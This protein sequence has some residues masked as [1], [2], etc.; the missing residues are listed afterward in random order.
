MTDIQARL[1]TVVGDPNL[2]AGDTI[3][4]PPAL[5]WLVETPL[6]ILR[7]EQIAACPVEGLVVGG[8]D[9]AEGL[10]AR[11]TPSRAPLLHG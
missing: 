5:W 3:E 1:A 8:A 2:F 4:A 11:H 10:G 9:L 6:G 7:V